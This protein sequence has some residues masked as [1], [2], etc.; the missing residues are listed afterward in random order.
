[1]TTEYKNLIDGELITTSGWM[2]VVNP[3]NESVIGKV[4]SCGEDEL[5]RAVTA[6]RRAFKTLSLIHISEP[7]RRI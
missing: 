1:M 7:T 2:D 4:P 5:N 3:A 6:A